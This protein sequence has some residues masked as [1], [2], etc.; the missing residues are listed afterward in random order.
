M[1]HRGEAR[2]VCLSWIA[3]CA[4]LGTLPASAAAAAPS[5]DNFA[6][7]DT[8]IGSL[9]ITDTG[10]NWQATAEV[11][12]PWHNGAPPVV[13]VW[14]KWTA[15]A[16]GQVTIDTCD[17]YLDT[18]LAVYTGVSLA[19]LAAIASN[20]DACA[21]QSR[22]T[23]RAV[24]GQTYRI[25][26]DSHVPG[27]AIVTADIAL[28]ISAP[29]PPANDNF[30][31][32]EPLPA[33]AATAA[34]GS[35]VNAGSEAGEPQHLT[36]PGANSVWW[37]WTPPASGTGY[38]STCGSSFPTLLDVSTGPALGFL[39]DVV[40][41]RAPCSTLHGII[42]SFPAVAGETYRIA[43][44]GFDGASGEIAVGTNLVFP[45]PPP[46][47]PAA[48]PPPPDQPGCPVAGN[49]ILGTNGSDDRTGTAARDIMFGAA[50]GDR[51][52]GL[53]GND[54]LYGQAGNDRLSGGAGADRLF[55]GAGR[56]T[57]SGAN[58]NDRLSGG[59]GNDRLSGNAG[60]DRF[61]AGTGADHIS[62]R[63]GRRETIDC[64]AGADSVTADRNDRVLSNCERVS[65]R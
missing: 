5:N 21:R 36:W 10:I 22:V 29:S 16:T 25:A 27:D 46:P 49:V 63:D 37:S 20:N 31:A 9:P 18:R 57:L 60:F 50:G 6:N 45:P 34:R 39:T 14:W 3:A 58:G 55:G 41:N 38:V 15:R 12:E 47:P 19:G 1:R 30:A 40:T 65:R 53:G 28:R 62:A 17:G 23:F 8:L 11:G 48:P 2:A 35:N 64:G 51:L 52:R 4:L 59:A 13:S 42:A 24:D 33:T 32:A 7:A 54:C 61:F 44:D 56:D 26:V 43:V